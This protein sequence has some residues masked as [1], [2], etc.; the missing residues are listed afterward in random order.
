MILFGTNAQDREYKLS[1]TLKMETGESFPFRIEFSEEHGNLR[2][3]SYTYPPPNETKTAIMGVVDAYERR[4]TFKE[5]EIITPH[6]VFTKAYMCL[7]N[8]NLKYD[9]TYRGVSLSGPITNRQTDNIACTPGVLTFDNPEELQPLFEP[10]KQFDT[11]ISMKK[12]APGA[13][14]GGIRVAQEQEAEPVEEQSEPDRITKG[15]GKMY[16]WNTDSL[17]LE[18][19]DGGNTDGDI[20]SVSYNGKE[21]LSRLSLNKQKKRIVVSVPAHSE[22]NLVITAVNEGSDPPNTATLSLRDGEQRYSVVAY[23]DM[24]NSALI[25]IKRD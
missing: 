15:I 13:Q 18:I 12:K 10:K 25:T 23:N 7:I 11:V 24:K 9:K 22:N 20:V 17:V 4:L 3:F 19:W 8:A 5:M 2:G 6:V 16:Y 1:G 21:I 14:R